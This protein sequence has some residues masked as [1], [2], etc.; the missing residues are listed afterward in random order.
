MNSYSESDEFMIGCF[1]QFLHRRIPPL[2]IRFAY[3]C[4]TP[5]LLCDLFHVGK[6]DS[7][8][9]N[10]SVVVLMWMALFPQ[11]RLYELSVE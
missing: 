11:K 4:R 7:V 8:D 3:K 5:V 2:C 6:Y 10:V 9:A 1:A